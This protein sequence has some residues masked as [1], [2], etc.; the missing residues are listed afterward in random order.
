VSD[1]EA[2]SLRK[3][4]AVFQRAMQAAFESIVCIAVMPMD[5]NGQ[6]GEILHKGNNGTIYWWQPI[7]I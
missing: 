5:H 4:L 6:H 1:L 3:A 2:Y 7:T